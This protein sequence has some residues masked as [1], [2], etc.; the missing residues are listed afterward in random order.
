MEV[1]IIKCRWNKVNLNYLCYINDLN[2][3]V[4]RY[5]FID[6]PVIILKIKV[7]KC[8]INIKLSYI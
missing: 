7:F 2:F 8:F 5:I 3:N 6:N 1:L 4:I